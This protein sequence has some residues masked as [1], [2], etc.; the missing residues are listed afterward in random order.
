MEIK[1]AYPRSKQ[2]V[3]V[4]PNAIFHKYGHRHYTWFKADD[5]TIH[6]VSGPALVC[7][8]LSEWRYNGLRHNLKGTALVWNRSNILPDTYIPSRD[9]HYLF[10]RACTPFEFQHKGTRRF[11]ILKYL[12]ERED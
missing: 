12:H 4:Y 5:R 1:A 9:H 3:I 6:R 7:K 8:E 11:H 2:S 10:G